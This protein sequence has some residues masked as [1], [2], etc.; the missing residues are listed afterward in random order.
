VGLF[1]R[2]PYDRSG[3]MASASKALARGDRQTAIAEYRKVLEHEPGDEMVLTKLGDLLAQSNQHDEA[4]VVLL[5]AARSFERRGFVDKALAVYALG[6]GRMPRDLELVNLLAD[7]HAARGRTAE[8]VKALLEARA[9]RRDRPAAIA[10][11][12]RALVLQPGHV[13]ATLDLAKV[14]AR[15]GRKAEARALLAPLVEGASGRKLRRLRAAQLSVEPSPA[16][17]WRWLRAHF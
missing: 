16:A 9:R 12:Q 1:E 10:L 4:R 2:K 3:A 13:D 17:L 5:S 7:R 11:L 14:L 15:E 6:V 8:A